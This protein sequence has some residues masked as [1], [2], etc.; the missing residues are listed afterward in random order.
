MTT[1]VLWAGL[2]AGVAL[3]V[4]S[5]WQAA[6][7]RT[8]RSPSRTVRGP[9]QA[10]SRKRSAV[11]AATLGCAALL[12]TLITDPPLAAVLTV[13][14]TATAGLRLVDAVGVGRW[15]RMFALGMGLLS[16]PLAIFAIAPL[17]R[18][19][20]GA[21]W[22]DNGTSL[23]FCGLGIAVAIDLLLHQLRTGRR[24]AGWLQCRELWLAGCGIMLVAVP[25]PSF[26]EWG[27]W[28]LGV[29]LIDVLAFL[30]LLT[31][32]GR[33]QAPGMAHVLVALNAVL[34]TFPM[35]DELARVRAIQTATEWALPPNPIYA[36]SKAT[37]EQVYAGHAVVRSPG[38]AV[39]ILPNVYGDGRGDRHGRHVDVLTWPAT[40]G[41]PL[42]VGWLLEPLSED[43]ADLASAPT[44]QVRAVATASN[45]RPPEQPVTATSLR[46]GPRPEHPKLPWYG[47]AT[48][49]LLAVAVR[50]GDQLGP[51]WSP[52]VDP[53]LALV[54]GLSMVGCI[55][56][57]LASLLTASP[58]L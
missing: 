55:A 24:G 8:P 3:A 32:V 21:D 4:L 51:T 16:A 2:L 36:E 47:W 5:W 15:R 42:W 29:A 52:R 28:M 11:T 18:L 19:T 45:R 54:A 31:L 23:A 6:R 26:P 25:V 33:R 20:G 22:P 12:T 34:L 58:R 49:A 57:A 35:T 30:G 13:A 56:T 38:T 40:S 50:W 37:P 10:A 44:M 17:R 7:L 14:L 9:L 46:N 27:W 39:M 41:P 53:G 48:F 1:Q 43:G